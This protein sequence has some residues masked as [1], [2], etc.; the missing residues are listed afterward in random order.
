MT[1]QNQQTSSRFVRRYPALPF[2]KLLRVLAILVIVLP[3]AYIFINRGT[4]GPE[5]TA[6]KTI[7]A[8]TQIETFSTALEVFEVDNGFYPNTQSGLQALV[9]QP[10]NAKN[11]QR[12]LKSIPKDPWQ[13]DYIYQYPGQHNTQGYDL[14]SMGSNGQLGDT[15]D[16][17]NWKRN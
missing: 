3:L 8:K 1:G 16:I 9:V 2:A 11:W 15:D 17:T 5:D 6:R 4:S 7:G 12:Y 10:E 14:A 13:H